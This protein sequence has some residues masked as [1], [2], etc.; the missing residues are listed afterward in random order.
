MTD[1]ANRI[2]QSFDRQSL[3]ASFSARLD[4]IDRGNVTVSAPIGP[5]VLQQQGLAHAGLTFA[6]GD[7]AAGYSA[8]SLMPETDEV[9]TAE[10]KINLLAPATGARLI[11]RGRVIKP[12]KRLLVVAADVYALSSDQDERHVAILQGTMVPVPG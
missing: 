4:R 10:M 8:L 2:R 11:A 12:G 9:V 3:L 1:F 6:L 7:T 5:D